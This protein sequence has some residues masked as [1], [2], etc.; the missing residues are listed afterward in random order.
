MVATGQ[1]TTDEA[2]GY[3]QE[4]LGNE[5]DILADV[6]VADNFV[7]ST[8]SAPSGTYATISSALVGVSLD[9]EVTMWI[10]NFEGS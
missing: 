3:I 10:E 4:R 9:A 8:I 7:T 5:E 2:V 1:R 6:S